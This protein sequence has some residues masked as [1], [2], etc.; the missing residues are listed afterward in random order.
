[1][2]LKKEEYSIHNKTQC[3][4]TS[5]KKEH[6]QKLHQLDSLIE[7]LISLVKSV[8]AYLESKDCTVCEICSKISCGCNQQR[9]KKCKKESCSDCFPED[10]DP[11]NES[12]CFKCYKESVVIPID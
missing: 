9:C 10:F 6:L 4:L 7:N 3:A 2:I 12:Q 11:L 1:M 5:M 8:D